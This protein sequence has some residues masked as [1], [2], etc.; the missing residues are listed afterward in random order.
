MPGLGWEGGRNLSRKD[1]MLGKS[2]A[3]ERKLT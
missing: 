1:R 3:Q 2:Q